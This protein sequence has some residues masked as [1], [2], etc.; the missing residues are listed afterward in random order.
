MALSIM[1]SVLFPSS[2]YSLGSTLPPPQMTFPPFHFFHFPLRNICVLSSL[3]LD[4]QRRTTLDSSS[5]SCLK[6]LWMWPYLS[7][8]IYGGII[9]LSKVHSKWVII[10]VTQQYGTERS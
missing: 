10:L 7:F 8:G 9:D 3:P 6:S 1:F 2:F 5:K 4:E